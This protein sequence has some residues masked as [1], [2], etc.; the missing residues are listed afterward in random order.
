MWLN[1]KRVYGNCFGELEDQN[2]GGESETEKKN[3]M[4]KKET[5]D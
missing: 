2:K 4:Q 1:C 3:G 5:A